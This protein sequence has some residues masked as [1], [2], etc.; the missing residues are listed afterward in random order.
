MGVKQALDR[1]ERKIEELKKKYDLFFQGI[2]R[3]E[4]L[5]ERRELEFLLRKMGQRS[6]PNT[7]D[8]FRFNTL[9]ARFYSYQNMWNRI[10][11]AIEEG[12]LVRDTKGR[13]SFS[14]HAPVDEENLNQT[15]LDYLNARK[16]A[17]LPV[18]NI[19]FTSFR[20]MLVKKA[21]E[22][23]DKSSCR[24]VEFRVEMEGNSPKIKAKRKN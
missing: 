5:N 15:F 23:Q 20:E 22:I 6:I 9:Q 4:P 16:E 19:D 7:A 24:K 1:I 18:D 13:V 2:L 8:Q 14:S 10:T 11:T 21:L 3:A 17:N 12:R